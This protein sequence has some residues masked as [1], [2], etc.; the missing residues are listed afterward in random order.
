MVR[1]AVVRFG[2]EPVTGNDVGLDDDPVFRPEDAPEAALDGAA[3]LERLDHH[4]TDLSL[5]KVGGHRLWIGQT[6]NFRAVVIFRAAKVGCDDAHPRR[7]IPAG[8]RNHGFLSLLLLPS[9]EAC[10]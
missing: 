5:G 2:A 1:A 4:G 3:Q 9:R 10:T 7:A 6:W 8:R